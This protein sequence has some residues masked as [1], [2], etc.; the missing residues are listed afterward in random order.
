MFKFVRKCQ[1]LQ[2]LI[3][4]FLVASLILLGIS[5]VCASSSSTIGDKLY[6][7]ELDDEAAAIVQTN[8]GGYVIAGTTSSFGAGSSDFWLFKTDTNGN[9]EWNRT[10][11][12]ADVDVAVAMVQTS[13]GGYILAG[14][15]CSF[16]AGESDFWLIK[17]DSSG[18]MRWNRTY[19]Q[20]T[21]EVATSVIQTSDGGYALAGYFTENDSNTD[22]WL[23]K[24]DSAGNMQW[25]R[26]YGGARGDYANSLIQTSD[27]GYALAGRTYSFGDRVDAPRGWLVKTDSEGNMEWDRSYRD[28]DETSKRF[29][30]YSVV[31]TS[32]GGY[33]LAASA[34]Y[35]IGLVDVWVAHV[36][37]EGNIQWSVTWG[38]IKPS[39][40][41]SMIQ[42][43]DGGY[44]VSGWVSSLGGYPTMSSYLFLLKV[45][46]NGTQRRGSL[47]DGLGDNHALFVTQTD[48]DGFAL[49]GTTKSREEGAHYDIWFAKADASGEIISEFPS[50]APILSLFC[51]VVVA[52]LLYKKKIKNLRGN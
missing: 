22:G 14:E 36:D 10:Y 2:L 26:T 30:A 5:N 42:T 44:A 18:S 11:G 19:G 35:I 46:S 38:P 17:V 12:G 29:E 24:T 9:M 27:G 13:D 4:V 20:A 49:A 52:G 40:T 7:G 51:C 3:S 37:S 8:D 43:S 31:Q 21:A 28:E 25:N 6:G 15:T 1:S 33:T 34:G 23:V 47:Y 50:W 39:I 16:G 45:N 32:D 48:D 41:S